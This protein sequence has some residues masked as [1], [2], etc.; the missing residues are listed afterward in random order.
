MKKLYLL[1]I[2]T[3]G[4]LLNINAK[5]A[6]KTVRLILTNSESSMATTCC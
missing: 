6:S 4:M 1:S 3:F 5:P 2:L